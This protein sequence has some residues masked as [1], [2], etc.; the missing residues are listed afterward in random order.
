MARLLSIGFE[1]NNAAANYEMDSLATPQSTVIGMTTGRSGTD[2]RAMYFQTFI[3]GGPSASRRFLAS[4]TRGKYFVR[5]YFK[6]NTAPTGYGTN[7][8]TLGTTSGSNYI[9]LT[10]QAALT[11]NLGVAGGSGTSV[12]S[13]T[14]LVANRWYMV[15]FSADMTDGVNC[16]GDLKID[17]R[18]QG[19]YR[20]TIANGLNVLGIGSNCSDNGHVAYFDDVAIN[21]DSGN[22]QNHFPG[23]GQIKLLQPTANGQSTAW[24]RTG[25]PSANWDCVDENGPATG[26]YVS[27][28][29]VSQ[30]DWYAFGDLAT[31]TANKIN[32]VEV[33]AGLYGNGGSGA[34]IKFQ[35][36]TQNSGTVLQSASIT[37]NA[38]YMFNSTSY[39]RDAPIV[40]Y[41]DPQDGSP[42]TESKVNNIQ[43]GQTVISTNVSFTLI[44]AYYLQVEITEP[45][46]HGVSSISNISSIAI[47]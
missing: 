13:S 26:D 28:S 41:T 43:A 22:Y 36:Q 35:L 24:S 17:G 4:P 33:L 46:L 6:T 21:D 2:S 8:C 27:S 10:L 3:F 11:I 16:V 37:P 20:S 40:S 44:F 9:A 25:G 38:N 15:E 29:T 7:I 32:V 45:A 19:S 30:T 42:W 12:T 23:P 34:T 31:N 47:S 39:P 18:L 1:V 14:V 5:F